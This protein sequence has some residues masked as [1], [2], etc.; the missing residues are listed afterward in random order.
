MTVEA[1]R[2]YCILLITTLSP[3][4][5]C[6]HSKLKHLMRVCI[7]HKCASKR[8]VAPNCIIRP[9]MSLAEYSGTHKGTRR[10]LIDLAIARRDRLT[11]REAVAMP[12]S[13]GIGLGESII[14]PANTRAPFIHTR[15]VG[16]AKP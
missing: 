11:A 2:T 4:A 13:N 8:E 10:H 5:E 15:P 6:P 9:T 14:Q 1:A 16:R 7:E 3:P 12:S